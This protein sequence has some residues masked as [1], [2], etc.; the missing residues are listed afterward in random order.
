MVGIVKMAWR[1]VWRNTRRSLVTMGAMTLALWVMV[2]YS[3]FVAGYLDSME[4]DVIDMEV[5]DIQI[6]AP[7]YRDNPSIYSII[8]NA[9]ELLARLDEVGYRASPNLLGGGLAA[10]GEYSAGIS[11][12]GVDP[13][14]VKGVSRIREMLEHGQWLDPSAPKGV[15]IGKKLARVLNASVGAE[16]V[17]LSQASDGSMANDL[18]TVR[19]ILGSISDATDRTGVIMLDESF[20]E[21]MVLPKGVHQITVRRPQ[22]TELPKALEVA[23]TLAPEL[24]V[25]SWRELMPT[26]ATMLDSTKG[27]IGIIFAIFY[28]AIGILLLNAML[29]AVFERIREFGVLKAVGAGPIRV[30]SLIITEAMIQMGLSILVGTLL[31]LPGMWYLSEVGINMGSLGGMSMSGLA[32]RS[33]WFGIYSPEI[34]SPAYTILIVIVTLAALYPALKAALLKPVDAMRHQ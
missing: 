10:S 19:G 21:L 1:N 31:A 34:V 6:V 15:V 25:Q 23:R 7:G 16:L 4:K 30:F 14:R 33:V 5:G 12:R 22:T 9:D 8:E 13:N 32:M 29:M 27:M 17:V 11:L 28:L 3:G 18:Y 24:E 26:I 2:L 20:R